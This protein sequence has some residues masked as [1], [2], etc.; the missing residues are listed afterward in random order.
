[1]PKSTEE[2]EIHLLLEAIRQRYH[3]DFR[4]YSSSSIT[5]R[6]KRAQQHFD[7]GSLSE[8]QD[9]VL[10]DPSIVPDLLNQL[11]VEVSE[12]FRDPS[13]FRALRETV[14]PHLKTYPSLKVWVAGCAAGEE[15]YSLAIL[16]REEGLHQR[17]IFYATDINPN[18]LRKAEAGIYALDRIPLFTENHR[19]SGSKV[20]LSEYYTAAYGAAVFDKTLRSRT[21]FAEH[22]LAS[23]AVFAEVNLVSC[24][25]VL[26]Y[27][28]RELQ[29][30]AIGL[31]KDSLAYGGFLALGTKESLH[32]SNHSET[33]RK[34]V[35]QER[36]Y[37]KAPHDMLAGK[38]DHAVV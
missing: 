2:I 16:F 20:S 32:F 29:D 6:L 27:F 12:M 34:F 38:V 15:L 4:G 28:D 14:V 33:F 24:R 30:R 17:T 22:N 1:M 8:L 3:Y 23:D 25:N 21:V 18:S 9:K 37:R 11:T 7:C 10:H 5:R 26:I 19:R 36:I 35:Q 31:F 13:F